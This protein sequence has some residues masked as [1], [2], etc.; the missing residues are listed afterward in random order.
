MFSDAVVLQENNSFTLLSDG[1]NEYSL[2]VYPQI[3]QTPKIDIGTV[4]R[5]G[6]DKLFS[7]YNIS[8]PEL[9]FA[10]KTRS[11]GQKKYIVELPKWNTQLNNLFLTID[12]TGDTGMGFLN[13]ELVT[14]EF[15][16]GIP[17]Q[18]GLRNF[19]P[20]TTA[21]EMVFYFRPM[22]KDASYLIDLQP[23]PTAIPD[24]GKANTYLTIKKTWFTPEYKTVLNF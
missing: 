5:S 12:Y 4:T 24:F 22:S 9:K 2:S 20:N 23:Y 10:P 16:K 3:S 21:K 14:D 11:I 17:W 8:F 7:A 19:L 1:K 6:N 15:Y 13:S 18:I